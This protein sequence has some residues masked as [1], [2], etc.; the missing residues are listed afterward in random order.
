MK[1]TV[2]I[3]GG[4]AVVVLG[5]LFL[6][7]SN[8]D[9]LVKGAIQSF[10]S[11]ATRTRVTVSDVKL[12]LE[13]GEARI[14]GLN[15]SNPDGFSDP[16]IF[17]LGKISVKINTSTLN[18]NPIVID[19]IIISAPSV[20]YEINKS[21]SSNVDVLRNNL[22]QSAGGAD[23]G[24]G[25]ELK[26]IIRKLVIEGGKAKVRIAALGDAQQ[27][28]NLPKI[29]LTDVSKKSGGATAAQIAQVL[30][31]KLLGNVKGSVVQ[32][33]VAKYLGKSADMFKQG[34][35]DKA[36]QVGSSVS[37]A[38]SDAAKKVGGAIKGLLGN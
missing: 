6:V 35:L 8:L 13:T 31:S 5:T 7:W 9:G 23:S 14:S 24:G 33:G 2:V 34:A 15:V 32:L 12:S 17:E 4:L 3:V 29:Q 30:S 38:A 19:E 37:G 11:E 25:D 21:G 26:M 22:S 18:Q 10:G 16:N 28:V 1:K 20:I 27:T 36:G